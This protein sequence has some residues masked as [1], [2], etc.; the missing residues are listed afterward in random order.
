MSVH[1]Y[2]YPDP[3][4]A[5]QACA[6][7]ILVR[8]EEALSG[9]PWASLA[10]SGGSSPKPIFEALAAARFHWD[11]VQLFWVDER[12]VPPSDPQSNF[13]M[14][15]KLL[16]Q[17]AHIPLRN[18]HRIHG[19]L[20]PDEAASRYCDE[21]RSVFELE[22]G[23]LPHF[24]LIHCGIGSD[25]HTAS[26]FPGEPLIEDRDGI[27]AAVYVEKQAQYRIT[28]LPGV[29]LAAKHSVV[30]ATG[31]DKAETVRAILEDPYDPYRIPAQIFSHHGR[32]LAWFLDEAA[33]SRLS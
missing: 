29:L 6:K 30:Y 23:E 15:E 14:A 25:G 8:L 2:V 18:V 3:A 1:R 19:E 4:K 10:I 7:H 24:D 26:L 11:R 32:G 33:A 13:G 20:R 31:L 21:I 9:Q 22:P 28:L 12:T 27:A 16:I 17:P 5:A